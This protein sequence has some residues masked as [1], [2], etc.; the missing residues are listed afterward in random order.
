M[1]AISRYFSSVLLGRRTNS[2]AQARVA[3]APQ[4]IWDRGKGTH[5]WQILG[6]E[7]LAAP[8]LQFLAMVSLR[9]VGEKFGNELV[10]SLADLAPRLLEADVVTEL[11][12]RF[13]PCERVKIDGIQQRPVEIED[14]GVRHFTILHGEN[15]RSLRTSRRRAISLPCAG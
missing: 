3:D 10:A 15:A 14:G 12:H 9:L 6:L 7:S 5:Q 4:Q 11:S 13:M 8:L 2:Y 1:R